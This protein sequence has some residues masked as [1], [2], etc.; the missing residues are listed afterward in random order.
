MALTGRVVMT[1]EMLS[2]FSQELTRNSSQGVQNIVSNVSL[3]KA[4]LAYRV[5]CAKVMSLVGAQ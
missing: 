5:A 3:V 1:P 2:Y 4:E